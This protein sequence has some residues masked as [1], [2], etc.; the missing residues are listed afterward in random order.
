M[1]RD[2]KGFSLIEVLIA[3]TIFAVGMLALAQMQIVSMEGN[4]TARDVTEATTLAQSKIEEL[5]ILPY[6]DD[7]LDDADANGLV[8]LDA[9]G[10]V[11]DASQPGIDL[12]GETYDVWWNVAEDEPVVDTKTVRVIVTWQKKLQNKRVVF[13]FVK[14]NGGF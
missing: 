9:T 4:T 1:I 6:D 8:G 2:E 12:M 7:S 10:A 5:M 11:A 3:L 14:A 13:D